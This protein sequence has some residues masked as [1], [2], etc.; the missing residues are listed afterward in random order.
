VRRKRIDDVPLTVV[1]LAD[2]VVVIRVLVVVES[3]VF[4]DVVGVGV[5]VVDIF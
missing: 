2:V 3:A 5:T 4:D 1:V